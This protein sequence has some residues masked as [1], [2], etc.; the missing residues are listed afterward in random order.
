MLTLLTVRF[1][2]H[3]VVDVLCVKSVISTGTAGLYRA[4]TMRSAEFWLMLHTLIHL[5]LHIQDSA[6]ITSSNSWGSWG[7]EKLN[8]CLRELE[9]EKVAESDFEFCCLAPGSEL[10]QFW[11]LNI[12]QLKFMTVKDRLTLEKPLMYSTGL[13][14]QPSKISFKDWSVRFLFGSQFQKAAVNLKRL[15]GWKI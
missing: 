6:M 12:Y 1:R 13:G 8:W 9:L 5:Y 11:M 4:L 7:T 3:L 10:R 15:F 2:A 14:K